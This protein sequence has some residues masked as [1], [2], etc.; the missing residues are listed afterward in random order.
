MTIPVWVKAL[1]PL[2]Q[3]GLVHTLGHR[4]EVRLVDEPEA[5]AVVLV[6]VEALD[7]GAVQVLRTATR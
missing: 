5:A 1:D 3:F 6:A 7:G 2:S 4:P